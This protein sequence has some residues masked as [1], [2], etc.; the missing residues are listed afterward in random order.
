MVTES[1]TSVVLVGG[2]RGL[3]CAVE[4]VDE[5]TLTVL[6]TNNE[7]GTKVSDLL[8]VTEVSAP[9]MASFRKS[10]F[11]FFYGSKA[12]GLFFLLPME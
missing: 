3:I 5:H 4:V 7:T 8:D 1:E 12:S 10:Y 9:R 11:F 2:G 6:E